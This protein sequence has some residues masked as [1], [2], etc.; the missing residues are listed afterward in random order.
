[1]ANNRADTREI[2]AV[3]GMTCA[4]CAAAIEKGLTKL[5]GVSDV[6][7]NLGTER[8]TV[9]YHPDEVSHQDIVERIELIGYGVV[10]AAPDENVE[11]REREA[12]REEIRR[13]TRY[14]IVGAIFTVPLVVLS[15]ARDF[16][17]L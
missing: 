8:A 6:S 13:Q 7:V 17:L 14:L 11:D 1:M 16:E 10:E 9:S 12:R 5:P 3:T 15:M 4:N 2:L